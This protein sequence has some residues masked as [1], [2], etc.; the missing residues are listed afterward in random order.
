MANPAMSYF[1]ENGLRVNLGLPKWLANCLVEQGPFHRLISW[2]SPLA[3][4]IE[5]PFF[6]FWTHLPPHLRYMILMVPWYFW[7]RFH[8][9]VPGILVRRG[10]VDELSIE[11][12]ALGNILYWV[13]LIPITKRRMRFS[14]NQLDSSCP[15]SLTLKREEIHL[16]ARGVRG[17]YLHTGG[18]NGGQNGVIYW[19]FGGA[20]VGGS[21]KGSMGFAEQYGRRTGCDVF[22]ID[23]RLYPESGIQDA[24]IDACRGYEWLLTRTPA[25]KVLVYGLSSG[26]GIGLRLLQLAASTEERATFFHSP[27]DKTPQ[28]AGAILCGAWIR[29]TT[30]TFSMREFTVVDWVGFSV[31]NDVWL[32]ITSHTVRERVR[33]RFVWHIFFATFDSDRPISGRYPES[34]WVH[35]PEARWYVWRCWTS[36]Q[37]FSFLQW[38]ERSMPFVHFSLKAWSLCWWE[39]GPRP[40][41][42]RFSICMFCFVYHISTH[43]TVYIYTHN[44]NLGSA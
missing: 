41:G 1:V 32:L 6:W 13:R 20:F 3:L 38:D 37:S 4:P 12:H 18:E 9:L 36:K 25:E 22:M 19:I 2:L 40:E 17:V 29:Y 7:V 43:Y 15:P 23:M 5:V 28:P 24:V 35:L 42:R 34:F 16:P 11:A 14:L 8:K 26:G 27:T 30:P 10:M 21:I 39:Q 31:L 44:H 33:E